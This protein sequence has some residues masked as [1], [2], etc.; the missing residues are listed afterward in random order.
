MI[1]QTTKKPAPRGC[2]TILVYAI[3]ISVFFALAYNGAAWALPHINAVLA[4]IDGH[5][6]IAL[7][8][9]I[10]AVLLRGRRVS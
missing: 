9:L 4:Q 5:S 2:G 1:E 3:G 6:R 7:A 10:A 8:I